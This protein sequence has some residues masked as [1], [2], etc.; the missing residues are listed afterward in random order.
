MKPA[1]AGTVAAGSALGAAVEP[2]RAQEP[3]RRR[4]CPRASEPAAPPSRLLT[5]NILVRAQRSERAEDIPPRGRGKHLSLPLQRPPPLRAGT[6]LMRRLRLQPLVPP[7]PADGWGQSGR[8]RNYLFVVTGAQ[9]YTVSAERITHYRQ[10]KKKREKKAGGEDSR[11]CVSISA[12]PIAGRLFKGLLAR[13]MRRGLICMW[14]GDR[15]G[16]PRHTGP[17]QRLR[18]DR[19][20][21]R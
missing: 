17:A 12:R 8:L 19:S 18:R 3:R 13:P 7:H 15:A 5:P 16:M 1:P 2:W 20:A 14:P 11:I 6:P 21:P 10:G 4:A 9:S